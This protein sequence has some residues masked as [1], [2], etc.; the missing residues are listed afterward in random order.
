MSIALTSMTP[1]SAQAGDPLLLCRRLPQDPGQAHI[2][3]PHPPVHTPVG[4]CF[5]PT[6]D[7]VWFGVADH[8]WMSRE[9]SV[10]EAA[11][12]IHLH[13]PLS[14]L[15]LPCTLTSWKPGKTLAWITLSDSGARGERVD[16]SGPLIPEMVQDHLTLCLTR[17]F[18]IEDD[19]AMLHGLL[20]HLALINA[21]DLIITTGGTGVA[22]TDITPEITAQVVHTRLP[23]FEQAMLRASLEI[24]PH[25][26]ISRAVAG[27]AGKSC[28]INLPGSPK[29]VRENLT[30]LLP[31]L[32]HT[33]DKLQGDPTPCGAS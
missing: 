33:L 20:T 14:S 23:G 32:G 12:N 30:P 3:C 2:L 5:G 4:T 9:D 13:R 6:R 22:P 8:C 18:L 25:A 21:Y 19:P 17:G 15:D 7:K 31:A 10:R 26:V 11:M 1:A 27:I 16:S 29:G 24:T 28:I